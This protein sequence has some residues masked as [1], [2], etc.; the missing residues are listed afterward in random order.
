MIHVRIG[1]RCSGRG[2]PHAL[3]RAIQPSSSSRSW[4]HVWIR[5]GASSTTTSLA[6]EFVSSRDVAL[7]LDRA[8]MAG[9][10][11]DQERI[12]PVDTRGFGSA[13]RGPIRSGAT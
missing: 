7:V 4:L 13:C 3:L 8:L 11:I 12:Q 9:E 10:A 5:T 1:A 2:M 6:W